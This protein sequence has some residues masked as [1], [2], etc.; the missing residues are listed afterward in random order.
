MK[1]TTQTE[2]DNARAKL[3][4]LEERYEALRKEECEDQ[5]LR[6]LTLMSLKRLIDQFKEEIAQ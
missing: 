6:E 3:A 1:L 5:N 2:V 4:E